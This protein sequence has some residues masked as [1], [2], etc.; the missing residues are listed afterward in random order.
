[1]AAYVNHSISLVSGD[2]PIVRDTSVTLRPNGDSQSS[3]D[4]SSLQIFIRAKKK[5][6]DI[7]VEIEDYVLDAVSYIQGK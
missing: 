4:T 1:M 2:D 7:F 3:C 6:N 5:I